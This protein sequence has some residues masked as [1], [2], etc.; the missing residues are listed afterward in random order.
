M[1]LI[2]L[3]LVTPEKLCLAS[4]KEN[5]EEMVCALST[6]G[7]ICNQQVLT[8]EKQL[9]KILKTTRPDIVYCDTYIASGDS[10][11]KINIHQVLDVHSVPYVGSNSDVLSLVLSKN[12]LKGRWVLNNILT[13][14]FYV[15][16]KSVPVHDFL[17]QI[18]GFADYPY[19]LKPDQEGN[20]RGLNIDSI[21]F[22]QLSLELKIRSLLDS[23]DKILVE[24][25]LGIYSDIREFTVAM[26]G[27]GENKILMPAEIILD[28]EKELRIITT[29]D[30]DCHYTHARPIITEDLC[31]GLID[32]ARN[33]F[34]I[35]GVRDYS[36]CD[37]IQ[38]NGQ[39]YAIEVNG[40][41]MIPDRWFD[42]CARGVGMDRA[43][44]ITAIFIAGII[45]NIREGKMIMD[46]QQN[47]IRNL[48]GNILDLLYRE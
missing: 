19:I 1:S 10:N 13:P 33:A 14:E 46:I 39:L 45:R 47:I 18:I 29:R 32:L 11:E 20:S 37:I 24:K 2:A 9:L 3:I 6:Y 48:P 21:V 26:I 36:R 30:K 15:I 8:S 22:D 41:P 12:A 43:Q 28:I 44:Y 5:L 7:F 4:Y 35:A 17:D 38:A 31:N 25:Y 16:Q 40:Q 27:N 42:A 23:Y 34:N